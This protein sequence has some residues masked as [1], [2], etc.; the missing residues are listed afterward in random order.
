LLFF[1]TTLSISV[2]QSSLTNQLQFNNK[3]LTA[4]SMHLDFLC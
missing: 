4:N 2:I 1:Y 3:S